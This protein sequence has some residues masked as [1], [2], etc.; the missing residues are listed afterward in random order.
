MIE[1]E[2]GRP[3]VHVVV[4]VRMSV[5][6]ADTSMT[7]ASAVRRARFP[8]VIDKNGS[9]AHT[10]RRARPR[11][12]SELDHAPGARLRLLPARLVALGA[13]RERDAAALL[14]ELLRAAG[15]EHS[16]VLPDACD[17]C[18]AGAMTNQLSTARARCGEEGSHPAGAA[19][20]RPRARRARALIE[21]EPATRRRAARPS[22][23]PGG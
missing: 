1:H 3:P 7:N 22:S 18:G 8:R 20:A 23:A 11:A 17:R 12:S 10:L 4:P 2:P 13:E 21:A 9:G 15:A 16:S 14:A 5:N 6:G 19:R